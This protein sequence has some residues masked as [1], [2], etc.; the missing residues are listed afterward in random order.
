MTGYDM[1]KYLKD[2]ELKGII[3]ADSARPEIIEELRR[4]GLPIRPTKKGANS[5][6]AGIDVL[7]RHKLNVIGD[8]FVQEMRNYKWVE[9]RSG[10][11]TNIPQD[12]NDHLIDAFRYAT[13]NVLSKPNYGTYAIR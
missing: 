7:K 3:Y 8:N 9:D 10:K 6:H 11:L 4:M 12:G 13:Y 2:I 1:A 5:V